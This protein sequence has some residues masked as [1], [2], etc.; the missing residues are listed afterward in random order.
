MTFTN[1]IV[2]SGINFTEGGPLSV[3]QDFLDRISHIY[4]DKYEIIA[5]VH[6]KTLYSTPNVTYI[7]FEDSKSSWLKRMKYEYSY[8]KKLSKELKPKYWFSMHDMTPNVFCEK[9][10]VYCHNSAPFFKPTKNDWKYGKTTAI[11]SLFYIYLYG[12]NIK[13]N[14]NVIVQQDWLRKEFHKKWGLENVV[15]AYPSIEFKKK[16]ISEEVKKQKNDKVQLFYPSFPRSFKNFEIICEAFEK[17][18]KEFQDKIEI[19]LTIDA[20]LNSYA[21]FV[22]EKYKHLK[23]L[24]FIGL[25]PRERVFELYE[26]SDAL[27]FPSRLESWG[28][29][30]TEFKEYDKPIFLA[31]L[32]YAHETLGD[33]DKVVF[34]DPYKAEELKNHLENFV[35]KKLNFTKH[36]AKKIVNPHVV[37]WDNL[38]NHLIQ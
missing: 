23:G 18:D 6:K 35:A 8:F 33:Y 17:L 31:D 20:S 2:V 13:K 19:K 14:T 3:M 34:F 1:K 38:L 21:S 28:L 26:E 29:P 22:V 10:F 36:N 27:I 12:I 32:P 7:E 25:Q 9:Q 4:A 11:F 30:I 5:L 24:Q 16:E 37:G 15:V